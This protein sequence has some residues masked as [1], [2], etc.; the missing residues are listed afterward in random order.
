MFENLPFTKLSKEPLNSWFRNQSG[1]FV[2]QPKIDGEDLLI[3]KPATGDP[4]AI[5]RH[6]TIYS[7][8][9]LLMLESLKP[10]INVVMRGEMT[11][12]Q[13]VF[14]LRSAL[15]R[16][17]ETIRIIVHDVIYLGAEDLRSFTL[18]DRQ[19]L[20]HSLVPGFPSQM[21]LITPL[22]EEGSMAEIVDLFETAVATGREGVVVKPLSSIYKNN[23]WLKLKRFD[24][25]DVLLTGA[26]KADIHD[27]IP[28]SWRMEAFINE[29]QTYIG[30]VS[31][32]PTLE[33]RAKI[34][35][36][37]AK[38][39]RQYIYFDKPFV[40]TVRCQEILRTN[41]ELRF[42]HPVLVRTREDK[43]ESECVIRVA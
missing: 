6:N 13:K 3:I 22:G 38:E 30:D 14:D 2:V 42:R 1:K 17:P 20:L 10:W 37:T 27:S 7:V 11:S 19:T 29:K 9:D 8:Q 31:S 41:G 25:H 15:K 35:R 12:G 23:A 28:W 36:P 32:G 43:P 18:R 39:D 40:A 24:S 33:E 16:H 26:R 34:I 21:E 5:N 4:Y